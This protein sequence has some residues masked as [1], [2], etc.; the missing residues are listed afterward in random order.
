MNISIKA[1]LFGAGVFVLG[2]LSQHLIYSL[3][4]GTTV[5]SYSWEKNDWTV[6]LHSLIPTLICIIPGYVAGRIAKT[7]GVLYGFVAG[8]SGASVSV[9]WLSVLDSWAISVIIS[10]MF[11]SSIQFGV[12]NAAGGGA[13]ELHAQTV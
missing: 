13:G 5:Y 4:S 2:D 6:F 11:H 7:R 10:S 3:P 12:L 1:I 8:A 9:I